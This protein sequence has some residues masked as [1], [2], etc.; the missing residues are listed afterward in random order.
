MQRDGPQ[1]MLFRGAVA[2][3]DFLSAHLGAGGRSMKSRWVAM[4]YENL[5]DRLPSR[6][7]IFLAETA[8]EAAKIAAKHLDQSSAAKVDIA[9][10]NISTT[11]TK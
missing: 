10:L 3:V 2:I 11:I 5:A 8:D 4:Y 7:E 6:T 9:L 1:E